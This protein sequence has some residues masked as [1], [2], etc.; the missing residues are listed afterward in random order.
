LA[1]GPLDHLLVQDPTSREEENP[2]LLGTQRLGKRD[3][4]REKNTTC[5]IKKKSELY[6]KGERGSLSKKTT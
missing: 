6:T 1:R 5:I 2:G 3:E 4:S